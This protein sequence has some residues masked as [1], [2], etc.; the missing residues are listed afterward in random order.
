MDNE[1]LMVKFVNEQE[2]EFIAVLTA[3]DGEAIGLF[4]PR[5]KI[6][7]A[8]YDDGETTTIITLNFDML[9]Y[10]GTDPGTLNTTLAISDTTL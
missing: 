2:I 9:E 3:Q 1:D 6:N 8:S 10:T 5:L 4:A 7:D